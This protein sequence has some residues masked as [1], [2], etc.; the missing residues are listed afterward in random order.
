MNR[1]ICD[2]CGSEYPETDER[3]PICNYPRQ[4]N[5]KL[6]A[7]AAAGTVPSK[8]KGGRFNTKNVEKRRK[9]QEKAAEPRRS[10]DPNRPLRIVIVLLLCAIMLVSAYIA[11]RFFRGRDALPSIGKPQ[12]TASAAPS[13]T[14]VPP[15]IPC[16]LIVLDGSVLDLEEPGQQITLT[17]TTVPADTTDIVEFRS[18]D[19]AVAEVSETGVITAVGPGQTTITITCGS[20]EKTCTVVCWFRE[21]TSV[22][23]EPT[24]PQ[25]IL[26]GDMTISHT[27]VT[28]STR[29]ETFPITVKVGEVSVDAAD[30]SWSSSE[31][32][33]ATVEKGVV[34]AV[35]KGTAVVTA[36]YQ[37]KTASCTV[38]CSFASAAWKASADDVTLHVGDSFRLTVTNDAGEAADAH[39]TMSSAGI[40]SVS[41]DTVTGLKAGTVTLTATIDGAD[42]SCIVRVIEP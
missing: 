31:P 1:I 4:G 20:Q 35:G 39:W 32:N 2:I 36:S 6:V 15:A 42:I 33:V 9:Q 21:E 19:P 34:T 29:N 13:E 8:V 12:T 38:R 25:P 41:G 16:T 26:E 24:Q 37:G 14:T 10:D 18:A 22:P 28:C 3:C 5:E 23:T 27:D 40:V 17:V 11:L 30:V 7:A